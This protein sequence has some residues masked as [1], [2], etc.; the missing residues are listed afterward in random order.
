MGRGGR[1][2]K[3]TAQKKLQG[4]YRPDRAVRNELTLP[5]GMPPCPA[6][7]NAEARAEW[8][9]VVPTLFAAGAL[10]ALDGGRLADYCAAHSLAV[11][12]TQLYQD[13]GIVVDSPQGQKAHPAVGTA[14][15]ARAQARQL[16]GEFGLTPAGRSRVSAPPK[17]GEGEAEIEEDLFGKPASLAV[18]QGGKGG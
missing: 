2:R 6:W 12:A 11:E 8:E 14:K 17:P 10:S 16:A 5:A 15:D 18:V 4:T 9:R 13:E 3:P 1:P 7:L